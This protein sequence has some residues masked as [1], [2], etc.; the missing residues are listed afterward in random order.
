MAI[1]GAR[2]MAFSLLHIFLNKTR[3]HI[4]ESRGSAS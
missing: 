3:A 2:R 1:P 4:R